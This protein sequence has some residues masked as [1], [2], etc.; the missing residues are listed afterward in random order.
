MPNGLLRV[1]CVLTLSNSTNEIHL[2]R[3]RFCKIRAILLV[4]MR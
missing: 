1:A 3:Q 4:T 2:Y